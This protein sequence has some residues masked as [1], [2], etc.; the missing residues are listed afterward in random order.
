MSAGWKPSPARCPAA[1]LAC[2]R[3]RQVRHSRCGA[4]QQGGYTV[5]CWLQGRTSECSSTGNVELERAA[6][7]QPV[8]PHPR[9]RGAAAA[10]GGAA[11]HRRCRRR[12]STA[13]AGADR[14]PALARRLGFAGC[15][16]EA[17]RRLG[18]WAGKRGL[19]GAVAN[20]GAPAP[21]PRG[22]QTLHGI[23]G[24]VEQARTTTGSACARRFSHGKKGGSGR[25]TIGG[26]RALCPI[27]GSFC[28]CVELQPAAH[29][30]HARAISTA[31]PAACPLAGALPGRRQGQ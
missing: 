23:A 20:S 1:P 28:T 5:P 21:V 31:A 19:T 16:H 10:A 9:A 3:R 11:C 7:C 6:P 8:P 22:A 12:A 27:G 4:V 17:G 30:P 18:S 25:L 24:S 29:P 15:R 2:S 26:C 13:L 14:R